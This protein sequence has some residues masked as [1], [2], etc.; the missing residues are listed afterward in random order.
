MFNKEQVQKA[1]KEIDDNLAML[2]GPRQAHLTLA[3]DVKL[4]QAV[5][6][7]YFEG[8]ESKKEPKDVGT[9]Q[10]IERAKPRDKNS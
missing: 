6:M 1:I 8:L 3:S 2:T 9:K 10:P 5:C 7:E 4:V